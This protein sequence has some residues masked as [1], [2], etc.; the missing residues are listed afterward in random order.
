MTAP[1]P[2]SSG[3]EPPV[4]TSRRA[5]EDPVPADQDE[6]V[7]VVEAAEPVGI[8]TF[9]GVQGSRLWRSHSPGPCPARPAG[10]SRSSRRSCAA[11][12]HLPSPKDKRFA[13]PAWPDN[14]GTAGWAQ[15][16]LA[17]G[18]SLDAAGRRLRGRPAADWHDVE[19]A[20]FAVNALTSALA[21]TNTLLGNPAALK[22]AFETGGRSVVRG[23]RQ[24]RCTTCGTTAACPPRPTAPRS[25]SA[26]TWRVT[27]GAV[28]HRDEV[29]E[30]IQYA[31]RTPHGAGNARW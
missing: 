5:V 30:L 16:Y 2:G 4:R 22:R 23:L 8:P 9:A 25:R 21:P 15:G 24:L 27:P 29:A 17:L 1:P 7:D 20:R 12:T 19:R 31:R 18:G 13:D 6:A 11:P 14:P 10:S 26:R 3:K 28:V